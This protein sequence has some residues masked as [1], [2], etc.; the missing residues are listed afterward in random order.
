MERILPDRRIVVIGA[1]AGGVEALMSLA[2]D[3]PADFPAPIAVV[4]HVPPDSPSMLGEILQRKGPLRAR[5]AVHGEAFE[6]GTIYVASPDHHLLVHRNGDLTL[7][8]TRGPRENHH[9]PSIDPL[10]RSA[11][12]AMGENAIGVILSGML[13]DGTAG[14]IVIKECGG[15]AVVQDPADALYSNMPASAI[16]N[17]DVDHIVPLAEVGAL[18]TRLVRQAPPCAPPARSS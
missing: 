8:V 18:L 9:R 11:A 16:E 1:S 2:R 15:I 10:F 17:A 13:D 3:L 6:P 5:I 4:L 14:L 7:A 12:L